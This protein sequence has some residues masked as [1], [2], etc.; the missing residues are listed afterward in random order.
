MAQIDHSPVTPPLIEWGHWRRPDRWHRPLLVVAAL[1]VPLAIG[2]VVLAIVDPQQITGQNGWFKPLKF[3]I[4]IAI[5]S[6]TLAWLIGQVDSGKA[7]GSDSR[8]RRRRWMSRASDIAGWIAAIGL[9]IEIVIIAGAAAYG[10]TS[11]FNVT[12]PLHQAMWSIMASSIV[13][14]WVTTMVIGLAIFAN[15]GQDPARNLAVRAGVLLGLIGM[16]LAFLMTSPTQEQLSDFQGI[17][18]AHAVGV[19]DGGPGLPFLGWSTMGGDLRIAHFV[20]LHAL[21]ALPLLVL[22]LE[23]TGRRWHLLRRTTVRFR[24]IAVA[25]AG[26]A[27]LMAVL[28]WQALIGQSII[29]P[30]GAVLVAG[31]GAAAVTL[32]AV[33]VVLWTGKTDTTSAVGKIAAPETHNEMRAAG[34]VHTGG[35]TPSD[36]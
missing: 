35:H 22:T 26:Y 5:Y 4:S 32:G 8:R 12:T 14:V 16:G 27:A 10:T 24:L 29:A 18:G 23:V 13:V 7:V 2:C 3:A 9:I 36:T 20:G 19:P 1:M 28:T 31:V 30:A 34:E 11:H 15:P 17:A 6:V 21:Q 25:A 33:V